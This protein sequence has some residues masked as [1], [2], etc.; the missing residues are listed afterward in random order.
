MG[1]KFKPQPVGFYSMTYTLAIKCYDEQ[2]LAGTAQNWQGL[3]DRI[4]SLPANKYHVLGIRHDRCI[5]TD[6]I[7]APAVEKPH[8]HVIIRHVDRKGRSHV[9]TILNMLGI[10]FRPSIDDELWK[11]HGVETVGN[12]AG[13]ALYLTHETEEA[14]RDGK[15]LYDI[16]EIVSKEE[17]EA[18]RE[19]Y[20]RVSA[21]HTKITPAELTALDKESYDLG[22]ALKS[23]ND[24]YD[25]QPF[26]VRSH[27]KIKTIRE[28]YDR[29]VNA[30]MEKHEEITRLCVFVHGVPNTGKTYASISALSNKKVLTVGGGGTG[31]FD[32]LRPDHDAIVIDDDVCPN[33]LNMSDNYICRTYRRQKDNPVWAGKYLVVTSNLTFDEWVASC[34]IKTHETTFNNIC[35]E[36]EHYKAVKSRFYICEVSAN[37]GNHLILQQPS[38]RGSI[39]AQTERL[40]MFKEFSQRFNATMSL[41]R[42]NEDEGA[43]QKLNQGYND[44]MQEALYEQ[45]I[46]KVSQYLYNTHKIELKLLSFSEFKAAGCEIPD[47]DSECLIDTTHDDEYYVAPNDERARKPFENE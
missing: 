45:Y 23:F 20:T 37:G 47:K 2:L 32:N 39:S 36:T 4:R 26:S 28:S 14:I 44:F 24:W 38:K 40:E 11:N 7:W 25:S 43:L 13:Y 34:G 33:L 31:K 19:G 35:V 9:Y 30:R 15:M 29:G 18:V 46:E 16:S 1:K 22:Y 21:V 3:C 8:I 17:V 41:Y 6:G 10:T 42:Q 5:K 27:A 12:F